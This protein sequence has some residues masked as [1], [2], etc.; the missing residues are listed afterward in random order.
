MLNMPNFRHSDFKYVRPTYEN[1]RES[2]HEDAYL[3][4]MNYDGVNHPWRAL[5][6]AWTEGHSARQKG[7]PDALTQPANWPEAFPRKP[8]TLTISMG[9][10]L[11]GEEDPKDP[12]S[13]THDSRKIV[14]IR[15]D[16]LRREQPDQ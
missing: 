2:L 12:R 13:W 4:P 7:L 8:L 11:L 14:W 1:T 16:K 6:V 3:R 15:P 5:N 9:C 10:I